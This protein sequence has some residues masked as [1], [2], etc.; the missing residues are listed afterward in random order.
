MFN[1]FAC[2]PTQNMGSDN[3]ID[4]SK[5]K[6]DAACIQLYKPV[7]GCDG[8]TYSNDCMATNAGVT[9]WTPGECKKQT[10]NE[11]TKTDDC[12]DK[13]K[14]NPKQPC[15]KE[16]RPVCGCD[17]NTYPNKCMAERNGV[18]RYTPGN[19]KKTGENTL[20]PPTPC[21]DPSKR[22]P[23][24][25][26]TANY[27]P[28]CGCDGKTYSNP[29][30]AERTGLTKWTPGE[31]GATNDGC[32]DTSKINNKRPCPRD[33]RPVCGCNGKTYSN[34]CTAKAAGALKFE[35]GECAN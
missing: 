18:I 8:K 33:Y 4:K 2:N 28:V 12:I 20:P 19:C 7:C 17:G 5:I 15:T 29:C 14:Y 9:K 27:A 6:P 3:C 26:C 23:D 34:E 13:S 21:I 11:D 24:L 16:L 30:V 25:I 22:N 35:K 32:I 31:C 1:A 10:Q